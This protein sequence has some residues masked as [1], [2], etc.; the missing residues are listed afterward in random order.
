M[1]VEIWSDYACPFC[2]M[3]KRRFE[4]ALNRFANKQ[5]IEVEF[6]SFELDPHA[7]RVVEHDVHTMLA[8]KYG[9][10]RE[11]AKAMNENVTNQAKELG[12]TYNMDT[13]K[14][15]NTFDA[16]RLS[17]FAA[18]HGKELEMTERLLRAYFTD[19]VNIGNY[20]TL[21]DL[22][23][24]VGLDREAAIRVLNSDDYTTD[25]RSDE[26]EAAQLGI[27]GVPFFVIDRKYGISGAQ[28]SEVFLDALNKAWSENQPLTMITQEN[29]GDAAC[30]DGVCTPPTGDKK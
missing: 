10:S 6:R 24:E 13:I 25:V 29:G 5:D 28:P 3:G 17:Q 21:A 27:R 2:Y 18:A 15:T 11:K 14:L 19:S 20:D 8:G 7:E 9:M 22:A 1:K 30:D 4:A 26:Q 12:L 16:H 23:E